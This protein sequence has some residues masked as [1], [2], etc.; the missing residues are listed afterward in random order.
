M[1]SYRLNGENF[2]PHLSTSFVFTVGD[3]PLALLQLQRT[4]TILKQYHY[5]DSFKRSFDIQFIS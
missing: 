5:F 1:T 3:S 4:M 2:L